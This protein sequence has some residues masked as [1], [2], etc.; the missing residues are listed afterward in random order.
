MKGLKEGEIK[1]FPKDEV[2]TEPIALPAGFEWS[3]FDVSN[4]EEC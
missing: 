2:P 3:E 4:D 1:K